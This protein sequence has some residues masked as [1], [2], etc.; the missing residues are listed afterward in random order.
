LARFISKPAAIHL[1]M[2]KQL[3]RYLAGTIKVGI[4]Y[5]SRHNELPLS[6]YIY[7]DSTWGTE[8][9]RVS[10]QGIIVIRYRGAVS[11]MSQRQKSTAYSSM[12]AEVITGH[13]GTKEAA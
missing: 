3:L 4:T 11:W 13:K 8:E 1:Q 7:T 5:S 10:F 2:Y 9:D 12:D 6:Y